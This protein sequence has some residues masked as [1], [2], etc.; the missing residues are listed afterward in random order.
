MTATLYTGPLYSVG[1][2]LGGN[3]GST[4]TPAASS[5]TTGPSSFYQGFGIP[6]VRY[7]PLNKDNMLPGTVKMSFI[8]ADFCSV[9]AVP[10]TAAAANLAAVQNVTS[11]TAMT[12]AT[13]AVSGVATNIPIVPFGSQTIVIAPIALD[14][15]FQLVNCT[16]GSTNVTVTDSSKF[17][18]GEPLVIANVGNAGG[19]SALLTNVVSITSTTVIVIANAPLATN[20]STPAGTGE[21]WG[22]I[23]NGARTTPTFWQPYLIAGP[24]LAF[25]PT[26]GLA[27]AV[28][29]TGVTGGTGGTFLI[30]GYD[31]YSRPQ[32]QLLTVGAGAVTVNTTKAFKFIASVVPQFTDAHN[33][34]VG[35]ASI[36]GL[37]YLVRKFEYLSYFFNGVG[38]SSA[39]GFVTADVTNP[40]TT[41]TGDS[42]GTVAQTANGTAR[43]V[44]FSQ[45]ET[46]AGLTANPN[47]PQSLY[48]VTPV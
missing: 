3:S 2:M 27:R 41:T 46:L 40:A 37:N 17:L 22:A 18:V 31:I 39:T 20:S 23:Y 10:T 47:A 32:T 38:V 43:L 4:L 26:Q 24:G 1:P 14:F 9:D 48:G 5:I 25:D 42:R 12:L 7:T 44:I 29:I 19:T 21:Q 33:Y 15:G 11:G 36:F 30:S 16:T 34:S 8:N 28:S 13:T 45:P 35:T 6:D